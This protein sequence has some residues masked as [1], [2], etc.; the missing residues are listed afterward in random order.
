MELYTSSLATRR[1]STKKCL[2]YLLAPQKLPPL[3]WVQEITLCECGPPDQLCVSLDFSCIK[4]TCFS[5]FFP[6]PSITFQCLT[7]G[8]YL[9]YTRDLPVV[10]GPLLL[11][12]RAPGGLYPGR[13]SFSNSANSTVNCHPSSNTTVITRFG[14]LKALNLGIFGVQLG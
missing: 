5:C 8:V 11:G 10:Q 4:P 2:L 6:N 14:C 1:L 9:H 12:S 13:E 7:F 3:V